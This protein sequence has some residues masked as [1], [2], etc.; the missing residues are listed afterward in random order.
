MVLH[1]AEPFPHKMMPRANH[2]ELAR[3]NATLGIKLFMTYNVYPGDEAVYEKKAKPRFVRDKGRVPKD[4][5][6]VR[7]LMLREPYT[8]TWSSIARTLQEMLWYNMGECIDRQ[9][10]E[11]KQKARAFESKAKGTLR[12]AGPDFVVPR[13]LSAV[14][15]HAAPGSYGVDL[16]DGDVFAGALYDR[17]AYYYA[18][19]LVGPMND[20]T[21]RGLVFAFKEKYPNAKPKRI[22]DLGCAVGGSTLPWK[23]A[24]PDA[25]VYGIDVGGPL[26]RY[27]HAR[28]E[29]FGKAIHYSQQN[30]EHTDFPDAFFDVVATAGV[31]HETAHSASRNIMK[32]VFRILKPGGVSINS[33]I[34]HQHDNNLHDQWMLDWDCHYNAEPFWGQWTSMTS[35]ELMGQAGFPAAKVW[36]C[37]RDR[38]HKGNFFLHDKPKSSPAQS[39]QG[40]IGK[41]VFW[42]VVK[43][44]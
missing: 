15:I 9:L 1:V 14:D 41:G 30:G 12:L 4:K 37:W 16:G 23:D 43:P 27:A 32:E 44:A 17:G 26:M 42:G 3:Q 33:D 6:E 20:T 19:G 8:Q 24:F 34:P 21:G 40:G 25:E 18:K 10:P 29:A 13:Y 5:H 7:E 22:L 39:N 35:K 31:F 2:D 28:A 38:D 11:L 36:E